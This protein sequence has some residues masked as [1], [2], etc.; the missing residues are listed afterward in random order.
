MEQMIF[1]IRKT[2]NMKTKEKEAKETL[3]KL[4]A[5]MLVLHRLREWRNW[6]TRQ[7]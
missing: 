1:L 5:L 2:V 6:Q 3:A 7:I 4:K